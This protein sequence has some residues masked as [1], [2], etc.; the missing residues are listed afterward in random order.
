[1]SSKE[2]VRS[3]LQAWSVKLCAKG[4]EMHLEGKKTRAGAQ[5][6]HNRGFSCVQKLLCKPISLLH[7]SKY[8]TVDMIHATLCL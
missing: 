5:F 4:H 6:S 3:N 8:L 2:R 7:A 1:M